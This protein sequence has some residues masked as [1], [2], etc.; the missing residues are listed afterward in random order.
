MS[1]LILSFSDSSLD[2]CHKGV[3]KPVKMDKVVLV[4]FLATLRMC[5]K[6]KVENIEYHVSI[7]G[8]RSTQFISIFDQLFV[9]SGARSI[10]LRHEVDWDNKCILW[11]SIYF[12]ALR[13]GRLSVSQM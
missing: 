4:L 8:L 3:S 11:T 12:H 6:F 2:F 10:V 1:F 5:G 13:G 7:F 9:V